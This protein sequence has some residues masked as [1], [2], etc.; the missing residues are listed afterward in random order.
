MP[1]HGVIFSDA[2]ER[3]YIS[4]NAGAVTTIGVAKRKAQLIVK[5]QLDAAEAARG[6]A[7]VSPTACG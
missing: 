3:D 5:K 7:R 2:I 1:E 6:G 4:F